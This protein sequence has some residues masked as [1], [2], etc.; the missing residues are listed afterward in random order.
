MVEDA[1]EQHEIELTD[2][3]GVELV[4]VGAPM[5]DR[6]AESFPGRQELVHAETVP[7]VAVD[8]QYPGGA[9][10]L[11]FE[12]EEAV[13]RADIEH[14]PAGEVLRNLKQPETPVESPSNQA[15]VRQQRGAAVGSADDLM[16]TV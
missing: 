14:G 9:A 16:G 12:R 4:Y 8:C 6:G 13:P 5:L 3:L 15:F 10:L 1:Q 11:A 7:C 2:L